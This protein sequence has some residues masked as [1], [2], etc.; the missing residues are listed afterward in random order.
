MHI[1]ASL[2]LEVTASES[3]NVVDSDTS[4]NWGSVWP[5]IAAHFGW[6]GVESLEAGQSARET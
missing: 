6:E 5:G 3:L 1:F 4:S 2:N